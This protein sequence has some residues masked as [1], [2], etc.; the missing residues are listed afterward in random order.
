MIYA[1]SPMLTAFAGEILFVDGE[2]IRITI[3]SVNIFV[4]PRSGRSGFWRVAYNQM[5]LWVKME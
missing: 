1:V 4:S 3:L 2:R 5:I